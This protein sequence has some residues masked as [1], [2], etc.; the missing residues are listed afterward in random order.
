MAADVSATGRRLT[1]SAQPAPAHHAGDSAVTPELAAMDRPIGVG[2]SLRFFGV[3]E[4][5]KLLRLWWRRS[6]ADAP[7]LRA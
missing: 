6:S 4:A 5:D 3:P 1:A 7:A 2:V